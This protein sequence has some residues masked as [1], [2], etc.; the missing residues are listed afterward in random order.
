MLTHGFPI[1]LARQP[2]HTRS[3]T[4][5]QHGYYLE[6]LSIGMTSSYEKTISSED[7]NTFAAVTGDTNPVHLDEAYAATTMFK[8]RIAHGMLSAG[9]I[10]TVLGTQ[11]PGPG[12][13]YLDQQIKFRAP[14]Y[15]NDTVV[16]TVTVEDIDPRRRR[17]S[18]K[19]QCFVNEKLVADGSASMMVDKRG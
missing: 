13:I 17:V 18:L 15:I 7:I 8:A 16:A 1:E 3:N 5:S 11:L 19:T 14:V 10:S 2:H 4:V 9:L 12:C 6:D